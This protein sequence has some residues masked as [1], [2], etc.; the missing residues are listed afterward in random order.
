MPTQIMDI[1]TETF[2]ALREQLREPVLILMDSK[3]YEQFEGEFQKLFPMRFHI[4]E[5]QGVPIKVWDRV[6]GIYIVDNKAWHERSYFN[7]KKKR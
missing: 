1:L 4:S 7:P 5:W 2:K 6:N 3:T